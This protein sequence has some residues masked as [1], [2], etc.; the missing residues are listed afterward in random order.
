MLKVEIL[1]YLCLS[2]SIDGL[3]IKIRMADGVQQAVFVE[4]STI[5]AP[6]VL[7]NISVFP[8]FSTL[9]FQ[10]LAPPPP[11]AISLILLPL[12]PPAV[13]LHFMI[14]FIV[15]TAVHVCRGQLLLSRLGGFQLC[16]QC[17]SLLEKFPGVLNH[18]RLHLSFGLSKDFLAGG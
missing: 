13:S 2:V 15:H 11:H 18:P 16:F 17:S 7:D 4:Q 5:D 6:N 1:L 12:V 10:H 9:K 14:L 8:I 3:K